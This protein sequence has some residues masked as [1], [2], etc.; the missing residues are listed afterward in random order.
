M[1]RYFSVLTV[2]GAAIVLLLPFSGDSKPIFEVNI[3]HP[4]IKKLE[5]TDAKSK[6]FEDVIKLL[7]DQ[8]KIIQGEPV[9]NPAEFARRMATYLEKGF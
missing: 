7:F 4:L 6:D 8:A 1:Y 9:K 2:F 3:E 5:T